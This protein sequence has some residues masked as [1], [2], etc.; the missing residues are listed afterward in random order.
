MGRKL[1]NNQV[2]FN[3]KSNPFVRQ[4]IWE[5]HNGLCFYT[6]KP[7]ALMDMQIDHILPESIKR[8]KLEEYGL[9]QDFTLNSLENYVPSC[10]WANREKSNIVLPHTDLALKTAKRLA[11]EIRR[12]INILIQNIDFELV[13]QQS[14][15]TFQ[16]AD[17]KRKN[18]TMNLR[19]KK[20]NLMKNIT[21]MITKSL[22]YILHI[23][24]EKKTV[25]LSAFLPRFSD[26][27]KGSCLI[28]FKTLRIRNC[29]ITLGHEEILD[30]L[31]SGRNT[32]PDLNL[33]KFIVCQD[34]HNQNIYYVQLGNVR[35]P[36]ESETLQVLL[37]IVDDFANIYLN[38]LID[39]DKH[40]ASQLF[41]PSN[42]K[43]G[44]RLFKVKKDCG[45]C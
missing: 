5:C 45:T 7:V 11:P 21:Y 36:L 37:E 44:F 24:T 16:V 14:N 26:S 22:D 43:N 31:C 3:D 1:N 34:H 40:S 8:E 19:M 39:I 41:Q 6:Q 25:L 13:N 28:V 18:Y 17:K 35:F 32:S 9:D 12:K 27:G 38:Y 29:A 15:L 2:D 20:K 10:R 42:Y 23:T 4:A 30:I 33:R